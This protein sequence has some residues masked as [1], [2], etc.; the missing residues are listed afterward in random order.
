MTNL[1]RHGDPLVRAALFS[2]YDDLIERLKAFAIV[3]ED[4]IA[5][6]GYEYAA[7]NSG[8]AVFICLQSR[9][10]LNIGIR[11]CVRGQYSCGWI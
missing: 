10:I 5:A 1:I 7:K 6:G 2:H 11:N 8:Y 3:F 9:F 4:M